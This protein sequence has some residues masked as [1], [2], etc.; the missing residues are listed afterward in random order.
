VNDEAQTYAPVLQRVVEILG[1]T[2]NENLTF[3][4]ALER[5]S[6]E[7]C[8]VVPRHVEMPLLCAALQ[9][10]AARRIPGAADA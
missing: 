9:V 3:G 10:I 2:G 4:A 6:R 1:A 5:A 7:L 8:V